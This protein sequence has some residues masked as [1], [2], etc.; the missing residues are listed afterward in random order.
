MILEESEGDTEQAT[1]KDLC[2]FI[3]RVR[4]LIKMCQ[5]QIREEEEKL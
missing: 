3:S 4:F 5:H 1:K 2:K